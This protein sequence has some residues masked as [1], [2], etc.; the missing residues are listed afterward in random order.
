MVGMATVG[1]LWLRVAGGL[2]F[3]VGIVLATRSVARGR[4]PGKSA[5][6]VRQLRDVFVKHRLTHRLAC[7]LLGETFDGLASGL[8]AALRD[9]RPDETS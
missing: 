9:R 4:S 7:R 5:A 1:A 3:G 8:E 6:D 2:L